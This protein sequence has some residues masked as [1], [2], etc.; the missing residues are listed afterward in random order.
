MVELRL[1]PGDAIVA[2]LLV[3]TWLCPTTSTPAVVEA[4]ARPLKAYVAVMIA[5]GRPVLVILTRDDAT[6]VPGS[7]V[8]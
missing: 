7:T 8:P 1:A 5:Q 4:G 3:R 6:Q 2:P